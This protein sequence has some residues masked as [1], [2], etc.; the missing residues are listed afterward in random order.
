MVNSCFTASNDSDHNHHHHNH[1]GHD[2]SHHADCKYT[3]HV[4]WIVVTL[5]GGPSLC[6]GLYKAT[7]GL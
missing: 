2:H 6:G 5:A 3:S 1:V 7:L 4:T